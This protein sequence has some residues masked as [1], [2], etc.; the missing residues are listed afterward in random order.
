MKYEES[1]GKNH[2]FTWTY[3]TQ[4]GPDRAVVEDVELPILKTET[5]K[6]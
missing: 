2:T 3:W 6:N 1:S 4:A 5:L